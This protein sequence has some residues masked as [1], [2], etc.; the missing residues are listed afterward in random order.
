LVFLAV[1]SNNLVVQDVFT[2][3][4]CLPFR[5]GFISNLKRGVVSYESCCFVHPCIPIISAA[6]PNPAPHV[7]WKANLQLHARVQIKPMILFAN[8][9]LSP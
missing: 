5:T 1:G 8:P 7:K 4:D 9:P 3:P 2:L 6:K